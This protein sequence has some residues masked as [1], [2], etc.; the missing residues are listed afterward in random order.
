M[1]A[2]EM[3]I[4]GG[5]LLIIYEGDWAHTEMGVQWLAKQAASATGDEEDKGA[6]EEDSEEDSESGQ[7]SEH[8]HKGGFKSPCVVKV[9]D[10]AHT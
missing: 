2:I 4:V 5:S 9:I 6:K 3:C 10:F 7:E 1:G 8:E